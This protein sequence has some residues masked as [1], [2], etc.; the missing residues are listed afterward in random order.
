MKGV[1]RIGTVV[2]TY[3]DKVVAV[4]AF[5]ALI[6]S[7]IFVG[8][9][10]ATMDELERD[11]SNKIRQIAIP[12]PTAPDVEITIYEAALADLNLPNQ[13]PAYSN[14]VFLPEERVWCTECRF[15]IAFAVNTCDYCGTHQPTNSLPPPED[16]DEDGMSD[17]W[18]LTYGLDPKDPAD[19]GL[20]S[21]SDFFTNL[22]EF[23]ARELIGRSTN[24]KDNTDYP[25]IAIKLCI[26]DVKTKPFSLLFK[27][28]SKTGAGGKFI[29]AVNSRRGGQ[30][31]FKKL[32]EYVG[33]NAGKFRIV[34][35][36]QVIEKKVI[37][38]I[39]RKI[40][41]SILTLQKGKQLIELTMGSAR[42]HVEHEVTIR[43]SEGDKTYSVTEVGD[44]FELL[45]RTYTVK[46]IDTESRKIVIW[47]ANDEKDMEIKGDCE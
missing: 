26:A 39:P 17:T 44:K 24:P 13:I 46:S 35:F 38:G 42:D 30:T 22:E 32:G 15:P 34:K 27:S 2:K 45:G 21:D 14:T 5:S 28:Y 36:K 8:Y 9:K 1:G 11:F 29:Y 12:H 10:T 4:L 23:N 41:T 7:V 47:G 40:D 3:Y 19:A 37:N 31:Y 25:P 6:G 20:D 43:F 16:F 33:E 18:E